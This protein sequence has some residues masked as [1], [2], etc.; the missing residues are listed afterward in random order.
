M[1]NLINAKRIY[2]RRVVLPLLALS[3]NS[4]CSNNIAHAK[5][6]N[7]EVI[8]KIYHEGTNVDFEKRLNAY[9]K[10]K[11]CT[12]QRDFFISLGA[13]KIKNNAYLYVYSEKSTY[14]VIES[15]EIYFY[16]KSNKNCEAKVY[17][18][19]L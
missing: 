18:N 3:V 4:A 8:D 7:V 9:L 2:V 10:N 13:K 11:N 1:R 5:N 6:P 17:F 12:D 19:G 14:I 16:L 15:W